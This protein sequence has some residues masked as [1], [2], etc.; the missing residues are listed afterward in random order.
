MNAF[1]VKNGFMVCAKTT[2]LDHLKKFWVKS[3]TILN[4]L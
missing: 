4:R 3:L 2:T 1:D